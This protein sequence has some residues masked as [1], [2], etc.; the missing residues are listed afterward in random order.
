MIFK[1]LLQKS[2]EHNFEN[3]YSDNY[4]QYR[5]GSETDD[6][7]E[8]TNLITKLFKQA[9]HQTALSKKRALKSYQNSIN[10]ISNEFDYL[11]EHLDNEESRELLIDIAA[12]RILGYKKVKL[13]LNTPKLWA[14]LNRVDEMKGLETIDPHFMNFILNEFD[15]HSL[16]YPIK[17]FFSTIG[18]VI[19]FI[20][21]QYEY[22]G[23]N[24]SIK[25]EE[26]DIVIDG[27][28]CWGDTALY[29]ANQIGFQ[30]KVF[31]F[32]FIPGNLQI[33]DRNLS[34]N[35]NLSPVI[36]KVEHPIGEKSGEQMYYTDFGPGSTVSF[37]RLSEKQGEVYTKSIDDLVLE[38]KLSKVNFIKLDIEGAELAALKGA[39]KTILKY[40]PKIA[41]ALYHNIED[42]KTIPQYLKSLLPDYNF[43]LSHCTIHSEE[44]ILFAQVVN[45]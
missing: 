27:G 7:K 6:V 24:I 22:R 21:K 12:F 35:P 37:E 19:D 28:A 14:D 43:Y 2:I 17:L 31:S 18:I 30:G 15:L 34:L 13:P 16:G 32:E 10:Y 44:T 8:N 26:G 29:F 3:N 33:F 23:N 11:Y 40:K 25:A 4:D 45:Q 20:I 41:V 5:F 1:D 38:K 9:Y 36:E 42:F 39:E